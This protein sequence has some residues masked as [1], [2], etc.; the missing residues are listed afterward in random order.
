M[1]K[2][3]VI[4]PVYNG[5][6]SIEACVNSVLA[7]TLSEIEV[8]VVNDGSTDETGRILAA[9][10]DK[11]TVLT[12]PN[13][14]QGRARNEGIAASHG[15]YLGF[16]DADDTVE[17]EMYAAMYEAALRTGAQLVQCGINDI[18]ESG[19]SARAAFDET[20]E[21]SDRS[22]YVFNYFYRMRHTNEVCNKLIKRSFLEENGLAFSDTREFFSEDFKLNMEMILRLDKICFVSG[23]YYNYFIKESGHCRADI[24]GRID[25]IMHLFEAVLSQPMDGGTRKGLECTAAVTLL[26]YCAQ[27]SRAAPAKVKDILKNPFLRHCIKTSM[28]Y[29]SRPRHSLLSAAL[30]CSPMRLRL[31]LV[32]KF[33][34]F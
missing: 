11:I 20:V 1:V 4:I 6:E 32:R 27:A 14:G 5:E 13:G 7:Q 29:R 34:T 28:T 19:C 22:D 9:Y 12:V 18:T 10:G 24:V 15:E 2:V 25:K 21:I 31:W 3:S 26:A 8:I 30:L 33:Y 23:V 17:P 16:V